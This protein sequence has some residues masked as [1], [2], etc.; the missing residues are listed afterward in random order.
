MQR[1]SGCNL[2]VP[3]KR[4]FYAVLMG[5]ATNYR[6]RSDTV[7]ALAVLPT[8]DLALQVFR[9]F[10]LLCPAAG[11]RAVLVAGKATQV[12]S[13]SQTTPPVTTQLPHHDAL[14]HKQMANLS[15]KCIKV[16][17]PRPLSPRRRA[18]AAP[19]ECN[20]KLL[21]L[22]HPIRVRCLQT[23]RP[24]RRRRWCRAATTAQSAT[25][26]AAVAG[27]AGRT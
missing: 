14:Y 8:R 12:G 9:V 7:R 13:N 1:Y 11:L 27:A 4:R 3:F 25:T 16:Q 20:T 19:L 23:N 17:L 26:A 6:G 22:R 24:S 21:H 2:T 10:A 5:N 15:I 18:P